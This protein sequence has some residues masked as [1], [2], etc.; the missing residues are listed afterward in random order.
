MLINSSMWIF[1]GLDDSDRLLGA[2]AC[3]YIGMTPEQIKLLLE[4]VHEN[5]LI[6]KIG[7][8][9]DLGFNPEKD[10]LRVNT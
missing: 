9:R 6:Y 7:V 10:L 8:A 3:A 5:E 2:S 1:L 4:P